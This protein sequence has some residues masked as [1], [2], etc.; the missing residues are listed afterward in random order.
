MISLTEIR[1]IVAEYDALPEKLRV[2]HDPPKL[3]IKRHCIECGQDLQPLIVGWD[4]LKDAA[5]GKDGLPVRITTVC[6]HC[7]SEEGQS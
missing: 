4:L 7:Q 3:E 5:H 1:R 2:F 6:D